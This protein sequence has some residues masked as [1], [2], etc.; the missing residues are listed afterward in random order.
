MN[1]GVPVSINEHRM[2][3]VYFWAVLGAAFLMLA[4]YIWGAWI[5]SSS[6]RPVPLGIDPLPKNVWLTVRICETLGALTGFSVFVIFVLRPLVREQRLTTDGM[7]VLNFGLIWWMDPMVNFYNFTFAYNG[8]TFNM[9]SWAAFI[10]GWSYPNAQNFPEPLFMMGG[11]YLGYW[12][13]TALLGC[14]VLR[15]MHQSNPNLSVVFRLTVLFLVMFAIDL[16]IE[17]II[18]RT[19]LAAYPGVIRSLSIFPGKVMQWPLYEGLGVG[20][21][22]V[23][24]TALRYFKDDHGRTFVERGI[25]R[26]KISSGK[27]QLVRFLALAGFIQPMMLVGFYV[28]YNAFLFHVDTFP[29]YPSY[30]RNGMCGEGTEY[31]CPNKDWVPIPTRDGKLYINPDD[32]RLPQAIRDMQGISALSKDPYARK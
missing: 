15:R 8:H 13:L 23:G 30:I 26:L 2:T 27:K 1:T 3:P 28:V 31:A 29:S 19:G 5:L 6:F 10:P 17:L 32:P 4:A 25:D 24:F 20:L 21:A 7:M 22:C 9:G 14:W 12:M 18:L 11:F 16:A